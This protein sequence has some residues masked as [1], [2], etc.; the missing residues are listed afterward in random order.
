[1]KNKIGGIMLVIAGII[2][3]LCLGYFINESKY[4]NKERNYIWTIDSLKEM[5]YI[6]EDAQLPYF[7][8]KKEDVLKMLPTP[9]TK[10]SKNFP[11]FDDGSLD[12]KHWVYFPYIDR[13][14]NTKDTLW[15]C[16]YFWEIPFSERPELHIVFEKTDTGW[17]AT[18]CIQYNP[19]KV[20]I[21]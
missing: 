13:V 1:M 11:F 3:G 7:L 19:E 15:L 18:S 6:R 20:I 4:E 14:Q 5:E 9:L 12:K 10:D 17:I 16:T 21:M 8:K 2:S